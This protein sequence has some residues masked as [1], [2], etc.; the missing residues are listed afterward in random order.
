[1]GFLII[2]IFFP[3]QYIQNIYSEGQRHIIEHTD[4]NTD[5]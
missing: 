5:T 3:K 2:C 1:M 4:L